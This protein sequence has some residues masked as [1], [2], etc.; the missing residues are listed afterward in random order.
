MVTDIMA[1]PLAYRSLPSR[2]FECCGKIGFREDRTLHVAVSTKVIAH[3]QAVHIVIGATLQSGYVLVRNVG[4]H[5]WS[6]AHRRQL[7]TS[8][9]LL[10]YV[11]GFVSALV[12]SLPTLHAGGAQSSAQLLELVLRYQP[13]LDAY[14]FASDTDTDLKLILV[15]L[16]KGANRHDSEPN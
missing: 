3:P 9:S 2:L 13:R 1:C 12:D 6:S 5:A 14:R 15:Y 8:L 16:C 10:Q 7:L 11:S 4:G